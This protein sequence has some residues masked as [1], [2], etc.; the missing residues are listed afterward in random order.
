M[1]SKFNKYLYLGFVFVG[2][3]YLFEKQIGQS[4]I[5]FGLALAF[6]PFNTDQKWNDRPNWQKL[7]L[8]VHLSIVLGLVFIDI[9]NLIK[10]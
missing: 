2:C 10:S 3:I 4:L 5:Y 6:D 9:F 7:I 1:K 8:I